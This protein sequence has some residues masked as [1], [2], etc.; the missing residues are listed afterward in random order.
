MT[1]DRVER[2][3]DY[4]PENCQWASYHE[5]NSHKSDQIR[6]VYNGKE[7]TVTEASE[8]AK[9]SASTIYHRLRRGI[10]HKDIVEVP[11][12]TQNRRVAL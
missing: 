12:Q 2:N 11:P 5:Q 9:V 8:I 6:L 4:S 1:L 3:K 10:S 7:Y